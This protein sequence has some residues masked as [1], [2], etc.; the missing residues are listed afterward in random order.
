MVSTTENMLAG[1]ISKIS[2]VYD[3]CMMLTLTRKYTRR[4]DIP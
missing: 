3:I 1:K 4:T 2:N